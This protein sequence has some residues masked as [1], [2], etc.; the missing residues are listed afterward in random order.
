M[1]DEEEAIMQDDFREVE[2]MKKFWDKKAREHSMFYIATWRG[3]ENRDLHD[4]FIT[5]EQAAQFLEDADYKPKSKDRMLEIGCGIGRMTRGFANLFGEVYAIDVSGEMIQQAKQH[6]SSFRNVTLYETNGRDLALFSEGFFDFCFSYIV[7]QHIPDREIIFNYIREVGRV[8]KT[9][10][11]FHFQLNGSSDPDIGVNPYLLIVKR[12]YRNFIR[13]PILLT[14]HRL[15]GGP[16]GF[17]SPA[18]LGVSVSLDEV[19]STCQDSGLEINRIAGE[20]T[21][22]MWITAQKSKVAKDL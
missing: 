2:L 16:G 22:Y 20:G 6:L 5:K 9:G 15:R 8:L 3:Y 21:Q 10:G 11:L 4:F 14:W 18:W 7:F 19:C 13:R 12:T 17:E 1:A